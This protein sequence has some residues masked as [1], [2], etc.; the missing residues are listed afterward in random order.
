MMKKK[1]INEA[2]FLCLFSSIAFASDINFNDTTS[3]I[4]PLNN[5]SFTGNV[6]IDSTA[7]G[8]ALDVQGVARTTNLTVTSIASGTQ[9]LQVSTVGVVSGFGSTC[10]SSTNYWR[11]PGGTGNVGIDTTNTVGIGTTSGVGSGLIVMGGNVGIGTWNPADHFQIGTFSS[12]SSGFEVDSN[13][14]VGLGTILTSAS[15]LSIMDGNVGI[16]SV[17]PGAGLSIVPAGGLKFM[18]G[19]GATFSWALTDNGSGYLLLNQISGSG[20]YY[21]SPNSGHPFEATSSGNSSII[22][23]FAATGSLTD[24]LGVKGGVSGDGNLFFQ[25]SSGGNGSVDIGDNSALENLQS[26]SAVIGATYASNQYTPPANGLLVQGDVG[27]GTYNIKTGLDIV[28]NVGIGTG[29][30]VPYVT[31]T[32]PTGGMIVQGNVGIG[33]WVPGGGL[34]VIGNVGIGSVAPSA[35]LVVG[36]ASAHSGT[37]GCWGTNGCL[38]YCTAGTYPACSTCTCL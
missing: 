2:L 8:Q 32:P 5:P 29:I 22:E 11:L 6:G 1:I 27:I 30:N 35:T 24:Y 17:S 9:C 26:G 23:V 14:N 12:S 25:N 13:G 21:M 16:G 15:A 38:G 34:V 19:E 3:Q 31:T 33:T 4:A 28:G 37:G 20:G 7:P 18:Q 36:S 10:G